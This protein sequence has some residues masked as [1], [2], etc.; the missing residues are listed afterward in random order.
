MPARFR[1]QG[2]RLRD[3]HLDP[4]NPRF[5]GLPPAS[6]GAIIAYLIKNEEV[7]ELSRSIAA[8]GGLMPGELPVVCVENG[9]HVVVEG[10]RRVC[11]CK[12]LLDPRLAPT[13]HRASIPPIHGDVR[14]ALRR[15]SVHIVNSREEAQIV[16]GMRHIEG[17]RT[18]PSVSKFMFFAQHFEAGKTAADIRALTGLS[19]TV[20]ATSLKNHYFLQYILS[21]DCW[22]ELEKQNLIN[23]SSLHK[24]GVDRVLRLF[25]TAGS[26][27]LGIS[28]DAR[29]RP[30]SQQP[31]FGK[32]AE[33]IV[34]RVFNILPGKSEITTRTA[35]TDVR[36]DIAQWLL[37]GPTTPGPDAGSA[38]TATGA[39]AGG[40]RTA[41]A[42]PP[43]GQP[44]G[45][46]SA[47][48]Q[49]GPASTATTATFAPGSGSTRPTEFYFENLIYTF[50]LSTPQDQALASL[51]EEIKRISRGSAYR[52]YPLSASF[53]TRALIEQA[54]KRYLRL[55][56]P[57]AYGRLCPANADSSLTA[58][59]KHFSNTPALFSDVN[60]RRV[61]LGLFPNGGGI[62]NLMDLNMHHPGLSMPT[63]AVLEGWVSSGLKSLL[64]YLLK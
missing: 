47:S 16:L 37:P 34:R 17:I 32:I 40:T 19:Q 10:N 53:L 46:Q 5:V 7:I 2:I 51:C 48:P 14:T 62:K 11:A 6:Q 15:I 38:T 9:V 12:V 23:Y 4:R 29:Y 64:E 41:V 50:A 55:N 44:T 42:G 25:R 13:E 3:L 30:V 35:Y 8:Y 56:D 28:S 60:I 59:L 20:V 24:K 43:D 58:I 18:W 31:E 33:H 27:E 63:G 36:P 22:T 52:Q 54:C 49:A 45:A 57:A 1:S 39:P 21:L 61:F 26:Q